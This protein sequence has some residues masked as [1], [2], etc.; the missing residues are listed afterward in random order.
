M[1]RKNQAS[2]VTLCFLIRVEFIT[3]EVD[4]LS[5]SSNAYSRAKFI[6]QKDQ[7]NMTWLVLWKII[8]EILARVQCKYN[9]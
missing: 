7:I 4:V 9:H 1:F 2:F 3:E 6:F 5:L 8:I